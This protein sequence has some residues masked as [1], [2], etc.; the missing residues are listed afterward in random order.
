MGE[1]KPKK[2]FDPQLSGMAGEFLVA[3]NLFKRGYQVSITM[4]NAKAI[5]LFVHN[6]ETDKTFNVQVKTL[7]WKNCFLI[8]KDRIH[9]NHVYVFVILNGSEAQEDYFIVPGRTILKKVNHFFGTSYIRKPTSA[10]PAINYG[11]LKEFK[12]NWEVFER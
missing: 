1:P 6:S 5:D 12:D 2:R 3:G 10:M 7:R 11:P 8:S 9:A 4:G